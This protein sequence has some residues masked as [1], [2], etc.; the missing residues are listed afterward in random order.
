MSS[1]R[2]PFLATSP[3]HDANVQSLQEA[4]KER[5]LGPLEISRSNRWAI[6]AGVWTAIFLGVR[7]IISCL[8][9]C[10]EVLYPVS[11]LYVPVP[12]PWL[13]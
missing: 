8:I 3:L 11:E 10:T 13:Y 6:L 12:F 9:H 5:K 1:E 7:R 2:E 4:K